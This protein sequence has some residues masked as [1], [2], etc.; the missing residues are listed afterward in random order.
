MSS[1]TKVRS[2]FWQ[3]GAPTGGAGAE[4]SDQEFQELLA[5]EHAVPEGPVEG[6]D[7][8]G[9]VTSDAAGSVEIDFQA[10]YDVAGIPDTDEVEQLERFLGGLDQNLPQ[11]SRLAAAKAFLGAVGKSVEDVLRDAERKIGRVRAIRKGKEKST[12]GALAEGQA[13]IQDLT[14]T[15]EQH[16]ARMQEQS[17]EL[18]AVRRACQIE[19]ARL[20]AARVFFGSVAGSDNEKAR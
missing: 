4:L 7:P 11:S 1:W 18:E 6:V 17:A 12:E 14:A 8:A 16:R 13:R 15:I 19:E 20:Q 10:Q 3:S 2:L 9:I 5:T